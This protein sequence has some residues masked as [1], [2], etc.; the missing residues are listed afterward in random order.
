MKHLV[1]QKRMDDT[2]DDIEAALMK[3]WNEYTIQ[4]RWAAI[5]VEGRDALIAKHGFKPEDFQRF[6][7]LFFLGSPDAN[8]IMDAEAAANEADC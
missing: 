8:A 2:I 7:N 1:Q 3:L 6:G 5:G 4:P